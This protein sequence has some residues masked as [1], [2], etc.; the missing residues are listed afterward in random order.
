MK[1]FTLPRGL[2]LLGLAW[3][4]FLAS[5]RR[6]RPGGKRPPVPAPLKQLAGQQRQESWLKREIRRFRSFAHLDR[7]YRLMQAGQ[8]AEARKELEKYL[9][10]DPQDLDARYTLFVNPV[11]NA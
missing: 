5:C 6:G 11:Q 4:L 3:I 2:L 1:H 8:L 10:I 9:T 7:A